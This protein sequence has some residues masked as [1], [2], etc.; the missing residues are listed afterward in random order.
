MPPSARPAQP[1]PARAGFTLPELVIALAVLGV[2]AGLALRGMA[3][4]A[5]GA[6]VRAGAA[7]VRSAFA[8]AR[9]LAVRRGER[10]AVRF[11]TTTATVVV[12][13]RNDTVLRRPLALLYR[14]RLSVTRDSAA[15]AATG[16]GYGGSNLRALV[17]R[18]AVAETVVVS[19][20]GRVR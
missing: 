18:G 3:H 13:Q 7:E 2:A 20:L 8:L 11:D 12:H 16:V 15:Y 19:R 1:G 5:D 9:A 14:V 6:A 4:V 17:R 10:A